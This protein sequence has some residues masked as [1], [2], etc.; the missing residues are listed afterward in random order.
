MSELTCLL[1]GSEACHAMNGRYSGRAV[2]ASNPLDVEALSAAVSALGAAHSVLSSRVD[3]DEEGQP[4]LVE[5]SSSE[6]HFSRCWGYSDD[7]LAGMPP[8]DGQVGVVH[9]VH[10]DAETWSMTLLTHNSVVDG[11]LMLKILTD[12]WTY[13]TE[14]AAG[15]K[16]WP[17]RYGLPRPPTELPA[18]RGAGSRV[19][20]PGAPPSGFAGDAG[21]PRPT[22][23]GPV[24]ARPSRDQVVRDLVGVARSHRDLLHVLSRPS[25]HGEKVRTTAYPG[26]PFNHDAA[27]VRS[28]AF[29][30][31]ASWARLVVEELRVTPPPGRID[32]VVGFLVRHVDWLLAHDAADDFADEVAELVLAGHKVAAPRPG[33]SAAIGGCVVRGCGGELRAMGSVIACSVDPGHSWVP[34]RWTDLR[35]QLGRV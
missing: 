24:V 35:R 7:R 21:R 28:R 16:P 29:A 5:G 12:L 34:Q 15:R 26:I 27:D 6:F 32:A 30:M 18:P 22:G 19:P 31:L 9:V 10:H 23:S 33:R 13:Y 20:N 11:P 4:L 1:D 17:R 25:G 3:R 8:L 14:A 2:R